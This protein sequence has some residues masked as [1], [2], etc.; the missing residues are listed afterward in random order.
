MTK[1]IVYKKLLLCVYLDKMVLAPV[2]K[3]EKI[4]LAR[5]I[6]KQEPENKA[7]LNMLEKHGETV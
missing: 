7:A 3:D 4:L 1:S 5:E 6:L 2:E